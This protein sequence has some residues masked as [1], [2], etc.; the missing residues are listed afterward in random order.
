MSNAVSPEKVLLTISIDTECDHNP[1][2]ERSKP[3]RF[4]SITYGLPQRLQPAFMSVGAVP[5]Y[6]LTVEVMEDEASAKAL[7]TLPGQFEFGTHLHSAFIEP[8]KKFFDY[9]GIDSPDFQCHCPPDIEFRKLENLSHLFQSRFGYRPTSFR[10]GRYG[11]G[12]NTLDALAKLGYVV[13]TSVTPGIRWPHNDGAVDY[14]HSPLQPYF[15]DPNDFTR[16]LSHG[17]R[18]IVEIPVTMHKRFLRSPRWFRPWFSTV[19]EM[20]T[21]V[22][23]HLQQFAGNK[24]IVLNMM[25][26]SMEVIAAASPYPQS[27]P[28]V[29]RYLDDMVAILSWCKGEG[30]TFCSLSDAARQ[31]AEYA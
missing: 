1:R 14:R 24:V 17:R 6:L 5:T 7:Q 25:F 12:N 3:L 28:D 4:D 19:E 23:H 13:D 8:E 2:W 15:P 29:Q 16:P 10:A 22:Q 9:S 26:H 30:I 18:D 20:K 31:F 27:E 21:M 11:A